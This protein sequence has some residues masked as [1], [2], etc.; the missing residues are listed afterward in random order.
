MA[1][2]ISVGDDVQTPLGKGVVREIRTNGRLLVEIAGRKVLVERGGAKP[3]DSPLKP[4][5]T[6]RPTTSAALQATDVV[7]GR[8]RSSSEI[9]LHGLTVDEALARVGSAISDTLLAGHATLRLIH[10]R[11]GGRIRAALHRYLRALPPV[12]SFRIDPANEG[13]TVVEF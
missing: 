5:R 11:R 13:V 2:A 12:R 10:G 3:F 4:S 7:V 1:P 8:H 6:R 9:D